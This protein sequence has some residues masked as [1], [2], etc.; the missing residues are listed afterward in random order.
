MRFL[1]IDPGLRITGYGCVEG[2]IHETR[3]VEAG[4]FRLGRA[5]MSDVGRSHIRHPTSDIR[6][7]PSALADPPR[8]TLAPIPARLAE[9]DADFRALL[10][11]LRPDAV[12]VEALFAHPKHPATAILMAHARGVL[13]LAI[14]R[15]DLPLIELRPAAVKRF[16]TGNGQAKKDQMQRAIQ[17][18]LSLPAPPNPPDI[19]DALAIALCA[20]WRHAG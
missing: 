12:A 14:R 10:E 2:P 5:A 7:P 4:I 11:R 16:L 15:A 3:L 9:L 19:A 17:T 13:L 8:P 20:A 1:G 6:H 18:R